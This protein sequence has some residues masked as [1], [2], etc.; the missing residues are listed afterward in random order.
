MKESDVEKLKVGD[1]VRHTDGTQ[2]TVRHVVQNAVLQNCAKPHKL[3]PHLR[4]RQTYSQKRGE[5]DVFSAAA[6]SEV[7]SCIRS[8]GS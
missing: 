6:V 1:R 4:R 2:G 8:L 5:L 3:V 7:Y